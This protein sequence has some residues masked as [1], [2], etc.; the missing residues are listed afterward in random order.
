MPTAKGQKV[1][2]WLGVT[3]G[4]EDLA[5]LHS[6]KGGRPGVLLLGQGIPHQRS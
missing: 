2:L 1:E 3:V 4:E 5:H 6:A